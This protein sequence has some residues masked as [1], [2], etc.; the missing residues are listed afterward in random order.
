MFGS[1][2]SKLRTAVQII[3][4][5]S[6]LLS[7]Q[8]QGVTSTA[9]GTYTWNSATGGLTLNWT[10]SDFTCG[11][12][13]AGSTDN[14]TGLTITTTTMTSPTDSTTWTRLSGTA[15]DIVGAWTA[16]ESTT[17]FSG[18]FTLDANGTMSLVV[19]I[20]SCSPSS[21]GRSN[22]QTQH[23]SSGYSV[24]F[25]YNDANETATSVSVT[26]PGISGVVSMV[27]GQDQMFPG[28][29]TPL[30]GNSV[31][32]GTTYPPLPYTYTFSIVDA[33][34]TS[35][36]TSTASCFQQQ[37]VT[38]ISPSGT[39][40]GT[41]TFSW[42][43]IADPSAV[44]GVEVDDSNHHN[45][46]WNNYDFSG[47]SVAYSGPA[48]TSGLTYSYNVVL[49]S[50]SACRNGSSF[51]QGSFTYAGGGGDTSPPTVP[52]GVTGAAS[53]STQINLSWTAS[54][55][56]VGVTGYKV[57]RNGVLAGSPIGTGYSDTGLTASTA[58]SYT[59]SACDAAGNCSAQSGAVTAQTPAPIA[60][61]P[62][63]TPLPPPPATQTVFTVPVG[64]MPTAAVSVSPSGTFGNATLLV[65]LDLSQV[66]AGG[67][68]A[69]LGQFAAGYS[70]Y[71][72][73]L[74]PGGV[75]GLPSATWFVLPATHS[76]ALLS[77]PIAP[78][79]EGLAQ[80]ATN[81]VTISIVQGMDISQLTGTELYV[82]YGTSSEEMLAAGRYRGFYK[83]Q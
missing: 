59:V 75:L 35:T 37:F 19:N 62:P 45:R 22:V 73:A 17:G 8:A 4:A 63:A 55:D 7:A 83:A 61:I 1:L 60:P 47:T 77:I 42:T 65:T 66:L 76:W 40:S 67:A 28:E 82:G 44:Y 18:T 12:P 64:Q 15:G 69:G 29:W 53:G 26:G 38:N 6:V 20:V 25:W 16:A 34:G 68:F 79:M 80:N 30:A 5:L 14:T 10:S 72:A 41:P 27:Y 39:V 81:S 46:I 58:Y 50:S 70:I 24:Q 32:F 71:V 74:V 43:G 23:W 13:T 21:G 48:L 78:Y 54:T 57:Y 56:N 2:V 51:A 3:F 49:R 31:N 52:T 33:S 36:T 11:G 9:S